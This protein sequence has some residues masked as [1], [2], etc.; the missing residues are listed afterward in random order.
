MVTR[1]E[2]RNTGIGTRLV[3]H[4]ITFVQERAAT[5]LWCEGRTPTTS[6]YERLGFRAGGEEYE[7]PATGP[8]FR[9]EKDL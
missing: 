6:F 9:F 8:H 1:S 2:M 3:E 4:G 5:R 7:T